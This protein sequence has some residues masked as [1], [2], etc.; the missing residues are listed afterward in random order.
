MRPRAAIA[1]AALVLSLCSAAGAQFI[2]DSPKLPGVW[3]P[4]VG[5]GSVYA[6]ERG[7]RRLQVEVAVVGQE[8]VGQSKGYWTELSLTFADSSR[9]SLIR[10][11]LVPADGQLASKRIIVQPPG[12]APMEVPA[13]TMLG[14]ENTGE[15]VDIR[16]DAERVGAE[17]VTTPA[18]TFACTR[19]RLKDGRGEIWLSDKVTPWG[20]VKMKGP[21][22]QR[23]AHPPD[24]RRHLTTDGHPRDGPPDPAPH[25]EAA[26]KERPLA[27]VRRHYTPRSTVPLRAPAIARARSSAYAGAIGSLGRLGGGRRGP[28]RLSSAT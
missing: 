11:L 20:L 3:N 19:Y 27:T 8:A 14:G 28:L 22:R 18:G 17:D 6:V 12:A 7:D 10:R 26:T 1:A 24:L 4:L 25:T 2:I 23:H 15:A 16:P 9:S 5:A 21:G 13:K